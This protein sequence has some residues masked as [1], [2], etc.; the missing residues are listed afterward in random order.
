MRRLHIRY[1]HQ[2]PINAFEWTPKAEKEP[3]HV[4]ES[5]EIGAC[6][7][8]KGRF[9]FGEKT[10]EVGP[11]DLFVVNHREEHIAESDPEQPSSYIFVN[12]DPALLLAEDETL[13]LP[14]AYSPERFQNHIPAGSPASEEL[15]PLMR[16]IYTELKDKREGYLTAAKSSMLRVCVVI[17][18]HFSASP[19]HQL[20]HM[21]S[22][23]RRKLGQAIAFVETNGYENIG[24]KQL[25]SHLGMTPSGAARFWKHAMG[26]G[27][28]HYVTQRRIRE[29]K[30]ALASTERPIADICFDCG[31]QSLATFYRLFKT[32]VGVTPQQYRNEHPL[33]DIFENE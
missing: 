11:G 17:L 22:E 5:L 13:L 12:F 15:L 21:E 7:S 14:F 31:F 19:G 33:R 18:R 2:I 6:V 3:M 23:T 25:A 10:Y 24:L 29:A 27:F 28:H 32:H 1:D 20:Q 26:Y 30:K 16:D 9:F 4:H 8:G